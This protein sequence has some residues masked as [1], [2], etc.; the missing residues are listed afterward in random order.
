LR[1]RTV[2]VIANNPMF[3]GGAVD[4]DA[5]DKATSFLVLCDSFNLPLVF[6]VDQPGFLVGVD[7]ERRR[8]AGKVINW[9]NALSLCTV[10]RIMVVLRK[11]FG[12]AYVNM[13]GGGTSDEAAAWCTADVSFMDAKAAAAI[14]AGSGGDERKQRELLEAMSRDR[15]AYALAGA[16]GVTKVIDPRE[17]RDYLDRV[18]STHSRRLTNGVGKHLMRTWPTSY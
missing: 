6:L 17:T 1:G 16:F 12:Q 5:C 3:K 11:S 14:V 2:G 18:L 7:A 8:I 4:A 9:M 15:S 13:G 10:P